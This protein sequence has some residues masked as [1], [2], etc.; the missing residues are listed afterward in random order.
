MLSPPL[1]LGLVPLLFLPVHEFHIFLA[2]V[3]PLS[4]GEEVIVKTLPL[5]ISSVLP[6]KL[7]FSTSIVSD[8]STVEALQFWRQ[9]ES[10]EGGGG[11]LLGGAGVK[12]VSRGIYLLPVA[13]LRPPMSGCTDI[14]VL[15]TRYW[16]WPWPL[17][18]LP[19]I[20]G[21]GPWP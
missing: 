6:M 15:S 4:P 19:L 14:W 18:L 3:F 17:H 1:V 20:P 11:F 16:C 13:H 5:V 10:L 21:D 7:E 2:Q 12:G 9:V 8:R